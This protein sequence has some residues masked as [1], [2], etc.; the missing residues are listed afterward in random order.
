MACIRALKQQGFNVGSFGVGTSVKLPG[1]TQSSP[2]IYQFKTPYA[3]IYEDLKSQNEELFTRNGMLEMIRRDIGVKGELEVRDL[4]TRPLMNSPS[5]SEAPE[6]FQD[7]LDPYDIILTFEEVVM[8]KVIEHFSKVSPILMRPVAV[9]NLDVKDS[10]EEAAIAAPVALQ[11]CL[12]IDK[13]EEWE[14]ELDGLL[15]NFY[16][17]TG[18]KAIYTICFF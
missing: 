4:V 10:H 11:L 9:V 5:S 14:E 1:A 7:N 12:M 16:Q 2:N 3:A 13:A 18:R 15:D 6:K 17:E 8:D